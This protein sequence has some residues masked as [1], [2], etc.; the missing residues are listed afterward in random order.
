MNFPHFQVPYLGKGMV[1]GSD[2]VFHV[3]I[4][5]GIALGLFSAIV[6]AELIGYLRRDEHWEAWAHTANKPATIVISTL[7]AITGV[8]IWFTIGP[9][10]PRGSPSM[11]RLFFWPWFIESL[12]FLFEEIVLVAFYYSWTHMSVTAYRKRW[13]IALGFLYLAEALVSFILISGILGFMLTPD[14]WPW[15][16]GFW[17]AFLNPSFYPQAALRISWAFVLGMIMAIGLVALLTK[18]TPFKRNAISLF[19]GIGAVALM[20]SALCAWWYFSVVPSRFKAHAIFAVLTSHISQAPGWFWAI[21]AIM[22]GLIVIF[23]AASIARLYRPAAILI[24]PALIAAI[25]F[26]AEY[27]RIRE[28]IRGPFLMPGYMWV[29]QTLM[30]ESPYFKQVDSLQRA[31]W[32]NAAYPA[33]DFRQQ[34]EALFAHNCT[35]CHTIGGLNDIGDRLRGRPDDA[36]GVIL[37]HTNDMVPWMPPFSGTDRERQMLAQYLY[38]VVYEKPYEKAP[39]HFPKVKAD[40]E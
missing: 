29:S 10:A 23:I 9:L 22:L 6:L 26:T 1:I 34:G 18:P 12:D 38:R 31:Y 24:T 39:A 15:N 30:K 32:I 5:H 21:N 16:P 28:F 7:G 14:G 36:I 20:L 11:L 40:T 37:A 35:T 13:H 17:R 2:A 8:G 4:S 27:E 25:L 33:P 3:L 19:G